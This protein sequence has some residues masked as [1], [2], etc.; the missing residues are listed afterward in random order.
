MTDLEIHL[1]LSRLQ[2]D[3]QG[4]AMGERP[5]VQE[6]ELRG[7]AIEALEEL[8]RINKRAAMVEAKHRDFKVDDLKE[9]GKR[10]LRHD[11]HAVVALMDSSSASVLLAARFAILKIASVLQDYRSVVPWPQEEKSPGLEPEPDPK[12]TNFPPLKVA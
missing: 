2:L 1:Q 7:I 4:A 9:I 5:A 11:I 10:W 3:A 8:R 6:L 12:P